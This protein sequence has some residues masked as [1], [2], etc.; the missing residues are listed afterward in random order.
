MREWQNNFQ[1]FEWERLFP[2]PEVAV[3]QIRELLVLV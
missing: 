2:A 1:T 3:E